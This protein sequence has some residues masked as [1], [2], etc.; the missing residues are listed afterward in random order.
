MKEILA[1]LLI[2]VQPIGDSAQRWCEWALGRPA[3]PLTSEK[4]ASEDL[5]YKLTDRLNEHVRAYATSRFAWGHDPRRA[6][7]PEA[8]RLRRDLRVIARANLLPEDRAWLCDHRALQKYE[9]AWKAELDARTMINYATHACPN[10]KDLNVILARRA[11][12]Q[13]RAFFAPTRDNFYARVQ[14]QRVLR[15]LIARGGL[16]APEWRRILAPDPAS[17]EDR[18]DE[19]DVWPAAVANAVEGD[20][21][22]TGLTNDDVLGYARRALDTTATDR[23][24]ERTLRRVARKFKLKRA[25][26]RALR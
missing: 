17:A 25:Q 15:F 4:R 10:V 18:A 23:M 22:V 5:R 21:E 7:R 8:L 12:R 19:S 16:G 14:A 13:G 3:A 20:W 24:S 2:Y 11:V 6:R 1:A 9:I 26:I